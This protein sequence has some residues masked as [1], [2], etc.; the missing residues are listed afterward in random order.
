VKSGNNPYMEVAPGPDIP[1]IVNAIIEI[2]KGGRNKYEL[3][4]KTGLFRLDRYLF[5]SSHYPGD[6][7]F[8][9]QTLAFGRRSGRLAWRP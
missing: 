2:P 3:D 6:Y 1:K 4:K 9:P 5:A 8:I 7:G